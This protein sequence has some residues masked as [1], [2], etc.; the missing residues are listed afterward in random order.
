MNLSKVK[1]TIA[2]LSH[3]IELIVDEKIKSIQKTLLNLLELVMMDN[4]RLRSENQK[5]RDEN[6]RLKG[7]QGKPSVRKQ[8]KDNSD[9]SSEKDRKPR[10]QQPKKPKKS[11]KKK[12]NVNI[13][14]TERCTIDKS[15]LPP[16]AQFKG[17]Q[18]VTVQD[19]VIHTDNICFNKEVY[20]S[21]SLNKTF[22]ANLPVG[23]QG[24]FGPKLK[25]LIL[26]LHHCHKTTES[27][28]YEFLTNHN[29]VISKATIS[30]ILTHHHEAFHQEKE[31]IVHEGLASTNYQQMDDTGA[32]VNGKNHYSHILCNALFTA[33]FTKRHKDRLTVIEILTQG[34]IRFVLNDQAYALMEKLNLSPKQIDRVKA[35]PQE[36]SL[37]RDEMDTILTQ[38]FPNPKKHMGARRIIV[39]AAAIAAYQQL[40]NAITIL[41]TDDAPQ[42][43]NISKY[44]ALCWIHDGRH[45]KKLLPVVPRHATYLKNFLTNYWNYYHDLLEYKKR[46][47]PELAQALRNKFDALFSTV[48]GYELLDERIAKTKLKK[49]SLLLSLDHPTLPLHNNASELGA[50]IQARYRDISFHTMSEKGTQAKDTF[51]TITD[52]ARKLAVNSYQYIYDRISKA[53]Q[54]PSLASL[55]KTQAQSGEILDPG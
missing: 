43:K 11:K 28:I 33:F 37:S 44:L 3:D 17:Y 30:R 38:L 15:Q 1:E 49:D 20:Y 8:S 9:H 22:I 34:E 51:M 42:Y 18:P 16:D 6:N 35:L 45:Y 50:R 48:T 13:D 12:K 36:N 52:T 25:A 53:Y 55:I 2:S 5:L 31:A 14:R 47:T 24:G 23:Y 39:E 32:R 29:I 26:E 4:D 54:M 19:I 7:E 40:P 10:G 21:P 27:A 46:P 41:L